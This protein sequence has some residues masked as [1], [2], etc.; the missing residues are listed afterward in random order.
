MPPAIPAVAL[1][2]DHERR[3]GPPELR[4]VER[5]RAMVFAAGALVFPGGRVEHH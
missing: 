5:A 4:M 2:E 3:G 1:A